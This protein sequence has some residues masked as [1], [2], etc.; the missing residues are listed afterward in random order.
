MASV[1]HP[2]T[3]NAQQIV[4]VTA[5]LR[6]HAVGA[7][8][9][10]DSRAIKQGDVFFA[11]PGEGSD[12]RHFIADACAK[13]ASA[14]VCEAQGLQWQA[15]WTLPHLPVVGLKKIAGP[16]A[17]AYYQQPDA[18][19]FSVAV[20]G[21]NGKTSCS[22]WIGN[23]LSQLGMPTAVIG[24]L[25]INVFKLG[26][27]GD[28]E[29]T[30]N[31]TPDALLLQ[32]KL[33]SLSREGVA[34]IAIEASS[35]GLH[36]ARMDGMHVDV[37]VF[38]NLTRDHL[39]YHLDMTAYLEAKE[40]LFNWPGLQHAVINLDDEN[41]LRLV[42]HLRAHA[43][44]VNIIGTSLHKVE[45][46][47]ITILRAR[48]IRNANGTT[49][50]HLEAGGA[51]KLVRTQVIGK[52]NV[53]NILAVLGVLTAKGTNLPAAINAVENLNAIPGRM[54]QLGGRDAPLV[55]VD[56]A[57]T[58]DA[59]EKALA[60]L[61]EV[62]QERHGKLW[63][64]FGCGGNRDH[65]KRPQMGAISQAA[66]QV[67]LTSDN[68]RSE[69]SASIMAQIAAGMD[70]A[71]GAPQ[72]IEDRAAAILWAVRHA[73][74]GDVVLL[75]GKGHESTQEIKGRRLP[76]LDLDHAALALATRIGNKGAF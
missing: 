42:A 57:H 31:T 28:F 43:P 32:R 51:S 10:A 14:V 2:A 46:E 47:G 33:A 8:L 5:W 6:S 15:E 18:G 12:G 62:A 55:V 24:T 39:D 38:T 44:R 74:R 60:T 27:H 19:M 3:Q 16:I 75:A 45:V 48:D 25:G 73:E 53:S 1:I 36:Q 66:D 37:A 17:N 35:I 69:E 49:V 56:Y 68:P 65:G 76:F 70:L 59:L 26:S 30:G 72:L 9:I 50:F 64:V 58:P 22:Q 34:A 7:E 11:Y 20:T 23:A 41:G 63:C 52:F 4:A 54:Q 40:I 29:V 13:Q 67:V 61:R 71:K 21:T